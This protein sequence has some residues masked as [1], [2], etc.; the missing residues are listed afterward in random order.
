MFLDIGANLSDSMY[1]GIYNG[2]QKHDPDL[3]NVLSRA[4]EKGLE[5]IIITGLN[6][7]ESQEAINVAEIDG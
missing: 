2:S 3:K 1:K 6:L 4:W 5:K 7:K